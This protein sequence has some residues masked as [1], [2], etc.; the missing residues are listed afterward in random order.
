M[1]ADGVAL[2]CEPAEGPEP[3]AQRYFLFETKGLMN[4]LLL[5]LADS[6]F[7]GPEALAH[8][9]GLEAACQQGEV[10]NV[11]DLRNFTAQIVWQT[12]YSA[13]PFVTAA[14][15]DASRLKE[16]D[17]HCDVF[18]TNHVANR[19]SR[20]Q[21]RALLST[22]EK[23]F[24]TPEIAALSQIVR[25]Q[26][27]CRHLAPC[28]GGA[29]RAMKIELRETQ[30]LCLFVALRGVISAA[31]RLGVLGP[32][33]AQQLQSS[34]YREVERVLEHCRELSLDELAQTAPLIDLFHSTHD[35]MYSR[36]FQ[37]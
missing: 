14:H 2:K 16:L 9:G 11:D 32:H 17:T 35:R 3:L 23:C 30:E 1:T 37:S 22:C 20:T 21:G 12:G 7:P 28:F 4:F 8:S 19:A 18:L 6:A 15:S 24:I 34:C 29:L 10:V 5:Q 25:E 33:A 26:K 31:V 36:L 13:L 27:L